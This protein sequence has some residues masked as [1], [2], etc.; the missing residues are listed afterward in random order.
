MLPKSYFGS[1]DLVV[2]DLSE[3]VMSFQVTDKLSIF[4]TLSLLLQ[5]EGI[6]L[7]NGE[8]YMETMSQHF[9]YTL[10]YFEYD[11]PF[12]CDQ[13]MVIGSNNINFFNRSMT[14][15]G[16]DTLVYE[17]QEDILK[18]HDNNPFY[19]FTEYRKN[20]AREQGQCDMDNDSDIDVVGKQ[21]GILMI[22]EAENLTKT[23][24]T[25]DE[26][27][28][29]ST[30]KKVGLTPISTVSSASAAS[31]SSTT[32]FSTIVI[33]MEEGYITARSWPD[34]SYCAL[35]IQL[36]G[37]F[38]LMDDTK[39]A[40][41]NVL[42]GTDGS[43]S[44]FRIVDGGMHGSST[45]ENDR[46]IIGPRFVHSRNCDDENENE[47]DT[48]STIDD[49]A[50]TDTEASVLNE[51][52]H[53]LDDD[54]V[55]AVVC[56][57][58]GEP[59]KSLDALRE[60]SKKGGKIKKVIPLWTCASI[61]ETSALFSQDISTKMTNCEVVI[62]NTLS[63]DAG[64]DKVSLLVVDNNAQEVTLKLLLS[65]FGSVWNRKRLFA[66]HRFAILVP[67]TSDEEH[68]KAWRR[69]FLVLI[70]EKITYRPM[71][72]ADLVIKKKSTE[73]GS[74]STPV[75]TMSVLSLHDIKFFLHLNEMISNFNEHT[76]TADIMEVGSIYDGLPYAQ[77]GPFRPKIFMPD[78]YDLRGGKEQLAAQ[79]SL[80]RQSLYQFEIGSS[81][82]V[83]S[84]ALKTAL[85]HSISEME[86]DLIKDVQHFA[87]GIGDGI[88][89]VALFSGGSAVTVWDGKSH[90]DVNLFSLDESEDL[91]YKFSTVFTKYLGLG[92][93][94]S[95]TLALSDTHPRGT[96]RVVSFPVGN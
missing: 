58:E 93:T 42:G 24:T 95:I 53:L 34:K 37:S 57:A 10:Q 16:V 36:W 41:V 74:S 2:V 81:K 19:R 43:T 32:I 52:L 5:P 50:A 77:V 35:D 71:S 27:S 9:D 84:S 76:L 70:R 78:D 44:S 18:D 51:S 85:E 39:D 13:G 68:S 30:L 94:G 29:I 69:N 82:S 12:I 15:H 59:C 62:S 60:S 75:Q 25:S 91:R 17:S 6:M 8:Y 87:D 80:G 83:T 56:G 7:K 21:A 22:V 4:Q 33:I 86:W 61:V 89:V 67:T 54:V 20:N 79:K 28:L 1:F 73:G 63:N 26:E 96:G 40:L 92:I 45:R 38:Q 72:L 3:T 14:D 55:V 90:I 47:N 48:V 46:K 49:V 11:V 64:S 31:S 23:T 65:I 66:S 88:V